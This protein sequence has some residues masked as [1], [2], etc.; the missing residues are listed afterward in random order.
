MWNDSRLACH[1]NLYSPSAKK[2]EQRQARKRGAMMARFLSFDS[3]AA[4]A[5]NGGT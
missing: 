4:K 1:Y 3:K 2:L 5:R